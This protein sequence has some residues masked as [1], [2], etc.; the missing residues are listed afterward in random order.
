[1]KKYAAKV[2]S[3]VLCLSLV[4][5]CLTPAYA[6]AAGERGILAQYTDY[7]NSLLP[8]LSRLPDTDLPGEDLFLSQPLEILNDN[9]D[10]N[11]AF[12]LFHESICV[13]ELVVT[14][15][16]GEFAASFLA[17]EL[18][19]VSAAY[20]GEVP[21]CL[22]S[23]GRALLLCSDTTA[24][25]I[26][27][28]PAQTA[29]ALRANAAEAVAAQARKE[30]LTLA[31]VASAAEPQ[32]S[33]LPSQPKTLPVPYVQNV[34]RDG[35]GICWAASTA[36]IIQHLQNCSSLTAD[37]VYDMLASKLTDRPILGTSKNVVL[38]FKSY[39]ITYYTSRE[40]ALS[41]SAVVNLIDSN[42]P[43]YMAISGKMVTE[44]KVKDS[45]H[46]VVLCGYN[47]DGGFTDFY[48]IMDP[49]V[50]E[51]NV[52]ITVNRNTNAIN[53][54]TPVGSATYT[55]WYRS[56]YPSRAS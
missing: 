27:G 16:G 36:S 6:A 46:A 56:V 30:P 23:E 10:T 33:V 50:D 47:R 4:S 13:G 31:P 9:D 29:Y 35:L 15:L 1:M 39:G 21:V 32:S 55:E 45:Y 12:F 17:A 48:Q 54:P 19:R 25:V 20:A 52:W 8:S 18:P 34:K 41:F 51:G 44:G 24:E 42:Y 5:A 22:V 38:A 53:Y 11:Y 3:L 37:N 26:V 40:S 43:I 2:L 7:A 14:R 49:N 28:E